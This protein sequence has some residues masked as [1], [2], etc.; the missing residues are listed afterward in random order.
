MIRVSYRASFKPEL[1]EF[2]ISRYSEPGDVVFDGDVLGVEGAH[3]AGAADHR[4]RQGA[5]E[6]AWG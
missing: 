2:F 6:T 5:G 1:P 3:Q 4:G